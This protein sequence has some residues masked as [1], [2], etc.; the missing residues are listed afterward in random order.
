MSLESSRKKKLTPL[1]KTKLVSKGKFISWVEI[2]AE[3]F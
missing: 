3:N 2:P 1:Q